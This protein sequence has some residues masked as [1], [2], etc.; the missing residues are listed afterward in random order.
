MSLR[1][2]ICLRRVIKRI[3]VAAFG[4][5]TE[6]IYQTLLYSTRAVSPHPDPRYAAW[7][8]FQVTRHQYPG[9]W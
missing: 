2:E 1:K 3:F 7:Q 8:G 6:L 5:Q 4:T 9:R